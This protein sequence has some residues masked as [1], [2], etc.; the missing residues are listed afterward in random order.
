MKLK[1]SGF[2]TPEHLKKMEQWVSQLEELNGYKY[3]KITLNTSLGRTQVYGLNTEN[4]ELEALVIFPGFRTTS[5]LWDLDAGL[6]PLAEKYCVYLVETN[7]QPNLSDGYS[8]AIKSLDY[9]K[10]GKEVLDELKLEKAFIAGASFGGLVCMKIAIVAPEKIKAAILLNP[11]CFRLISFGAKNMYYN[12]LPM[13]NTNE[14]NISKFLDQVIFNTPQKDISEQAYQHLI[15]FL[16]LA[17]T[18]YKDRTQKPY[19]MA[20]QLDQVPVPTYLLVGNKDI[21]IP[22]EKSVANAKKHLKEN[23]KEV[24]VVNYG[25]GVELSNEAIGF[26]EEVMEKE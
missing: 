4:K 23:L 18:G 15:D 8:P 7:G 26:I 21:L 17:I 22:Y 10:W 6:K 1:L 11:G 5:L 3:H 20:E 9:G 13:V 14:K 2:K 19:Y 24:K 25:H 16:H 12:L